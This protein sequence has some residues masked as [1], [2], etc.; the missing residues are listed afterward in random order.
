MLTAHNQVSMSSQCD[1]TTKRAWDHWFQK[2]Q[3]WKWE[4]Y[5]PNIH[6]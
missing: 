4:E 5:S 2:Q 6:Y 3:D 1:T